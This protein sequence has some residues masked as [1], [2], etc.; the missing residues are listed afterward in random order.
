MTW[1]IACTG[2]L[3]MLLLVSVFPRFTISFG[4]AVSDIHCFRDTG[5]FYP[6]VCVFGYLLCQR[7]RYVF[8][9][10]RFRAAAE[11]WW[12]GER[13]RG[14]HRVVT[15]YLNRW[16]ENWG[17]SRHRH[18]IAQFPCKDDTGLVFVQSAESAVPLISQSVLYLCRVQCL[19]TLPP[20]NF[21]VLSVLYIL[22]FL[23]AKNQE[24]QM[25]NLQ[26]QDAGN[27]GEYGV[28]DI[29]GTK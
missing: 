9:G 14:S 13:N 7:L 18:L 5:H 21:F 22:V 17:F 16:G 12:R 6:C 2:Y 10:Y 25:Q 28:K 15:P 26:Q 4:I 27:E 3:L 29:I 23:V 19:P 20:F 1:D 8:T 24:L 11:L